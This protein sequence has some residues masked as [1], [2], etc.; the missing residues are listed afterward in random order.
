[1]DKSLFFQ[2]Q[3]FNTLRTFCTVVVEGSFSNAALEL[4]TS[5]PA[6]SLQIQSLEKYLDVILFER[7]GPKICITPDGRALY[8]MAMPALSTIEALPDQFLSSRGELQH[9]DLTLVGGETALLNILPPYLKLFSTRYP[10]INLIIH[11][12]LTQ[13][14]PEIILS[15]KADFAIGSLFEENDELLYSPIFKF[16]SLLIMP[17]NHPLAELETI[18]LRDIAAY[19]LIMP[20]EYSYSWWS[21]NQV[22]KNN[23]IECPSQLTVSSSEAVKRYVREG[24]GVAIIMSAGEI[25]YNDLIAVPMSRYFP[26]RDYGL[27]QRRGKFLSPQARKFK[28]LL[29]SN[30]IQLPK[31]KLLHT[32][33]VPSLS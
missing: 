30:E 11:S 14:I 27:I 21:I 9:G 12:T 29:L 19:T 26:H 23:N 15:N 20:P 1:M 28:E 5:Q 24:L 25:N 7:K 18:T 32:P 33:V 2:R 31:A 22:F 4:K 6:V 10:N 3:F 17:H 13:T 8:E 16:P